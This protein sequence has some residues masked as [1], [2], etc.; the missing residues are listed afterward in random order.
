MLTLGSPRFYRVAAAATVAML[1]SRLPSGPHLVAQI[2]RRMRKQNRSKGWGGTGW[3]DG[4]NV[5]T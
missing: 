3:G 2:E 4:G 1:P 5:R